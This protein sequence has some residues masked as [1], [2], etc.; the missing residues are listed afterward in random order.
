M[1]FHE[2]QVKQKNFSIATKTIHDSSNKK[3]HLISTFASVILLWTNSFQWTAKPIEFFFEMGMKIIIIT[4][5]WLVNHLETEKIF[6]YQI[7][8]NEFSK[9][10]KTS[11]EISCWRFFISI[12]VSLLNDLRKILLFH[13][14]RKQ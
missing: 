11:F 7:V 6:I 4:F 14:S 1:A 2:N 13:Q 8:A 5:V 12:L 9:I 3:W 10:L